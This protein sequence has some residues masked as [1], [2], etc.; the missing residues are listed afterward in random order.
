MTTRDSDGPALLG[1]R[2]ALRI[3]GAGAAALPLVA[4]CGDDDGDDT[5]DRD[6]GGADDLGTGG[7][8]LGTGGDDL[9]MAEDDLGMEGSRDFGPGADDWASGGTSAMLDLATYPDPFETIDATSCPLTV[10]ATVGPCY[11]AESLFR[12]DISE[13]NLGLPVRLLFRVLDESCQPIEF[14]RVEVWHTRYDGIYSAGPTAMCTGGDAEATA[15]EFFRGSLAADE[16]GKVAF[17][18]CF[19]GWYAGRAVHIHFRVFVD[20]IDVGVSQ[21]FFPEALVTEIFA[22]QPQYSDAGQPDTTNAEDGIY[23]EVGTSGI[24]E[25]ARMS[26]GAMLVWKDVVISRG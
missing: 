6:L 26:D 23:D 10:E 25:Y 24:A 8:D 4:A 2:A 11:V 7:D 20:D 1:R 21:L 3:L 12:E 18:T 9:G 5:T 16:E 17:N 19:P 15:S 14:A 13:G 22:S